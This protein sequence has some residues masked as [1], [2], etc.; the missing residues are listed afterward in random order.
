MSSA[1]GMHKPNIWAQINTKLPVETMKNLN[2]EL[3]CRSKAIFE[4]HYEDEEEIEFEQKKE[5]QKINLCENISVKL[6]HNR[7]TGEEKETWANVNWN[8]YGLRS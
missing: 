4:K 6:Q 1:N 7:E 2:K 5:N 3:N 8:D